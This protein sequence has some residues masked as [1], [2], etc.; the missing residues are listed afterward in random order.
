MARDVGL[1]HNVKTSSGA[2]S[3]RIGR[4]VAK[5]QV[6]HSLPSNAEVTIAWRDILL[7]SYTLLPA[8]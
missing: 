1:R 3:L 7:S 5:E 6:D 4:N 2:Q 8:L